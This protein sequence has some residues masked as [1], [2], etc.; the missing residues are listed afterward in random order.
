MYSLTMFRFPQTLLAATEQSKL[1]MKYSSVALS[2]ATFTAD[3][4]PTAKSRQKMRKEDFMLSN[5]VRYGAKRLKAVYLG[6]SS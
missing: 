6:S 2:G 4:Q 3:A 1:L 5:T